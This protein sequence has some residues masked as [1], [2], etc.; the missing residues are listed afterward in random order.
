MCVCVC[1]LGFTIAACYHECKVK[2]E[3]RRLEESQASPKT[4]LETVL[5]ADICD[6]IVGFTQSWH[7]L[8]AHRQAGDETRDKLIK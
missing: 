4:F 2:F 6:N 1:V 8:K 5:N 3:N 7:K